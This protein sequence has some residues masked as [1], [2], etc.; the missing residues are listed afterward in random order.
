MDRT[1][2]SDYPFLFVFVDRNA[3]FVEAARRAFPESLF[4]FHVGDIANA[5][6]VFSE[7]D[8]AQ[9]ALVSPANSLLFMDGGVDDAIR[10]L[11]PG[12]EAKAKERMRK[13]GILSLLKRPY[14]PVGAAM[15]TRAANGGTLISA[16]TMLLPQDVSQT[17]N[18]FHAFRA[19]LDIIQ[20]PPWSFRVV[21]CPGFCCGWGKMDPEQAVS[22][23]RLAWNES[24][25]GEGW[26]F[27]SDTDADVTL[28]V[29][30]PLDEQPEYYENSEW[31][32][33][34]P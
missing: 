32:P 22:Q 4:R 8:V 19:V 26:P 2:S 14:L 24:Q 33:I 30:E 15:L 3:A 25:A 16:P 34:T 13:L 23:M 20:A 31:F 27:R 5:I 6:Q 12:A 29:F 7:G 1:R 28:P 11:L 21:L 10:K 18:A 17:R 9:C